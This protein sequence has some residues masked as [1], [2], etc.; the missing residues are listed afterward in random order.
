LAR[1]E[2]H[3]L[4]AA[5]RIVEFCCILDV[6]YCDEETEMPESPADILPKKT[7][8]YALRKVTLV[9]FI[10]NM[11]KVCGQSLLML[12]IEYK[13]SVLV[14]RCLRDMAPEYQQ[15]STRLMSRLG[16]FCAPWRH[17]N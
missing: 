11:C 4:L 14:Y 13:L 9:I 10:S 3:A 5:T 12:L 16:D 1:L 17:R 8:F 7:N 2:L 6:N 15:L